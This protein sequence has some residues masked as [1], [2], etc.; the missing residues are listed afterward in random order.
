MNVNPL[1]FFI[2]S[3]LGNLTGACSLLLVSHVDP[4]IINGITAKDLVVINI[5]SS[6]IGAAAN[7]IGYHFADRK[8]GEEGTRFKKNL[9][10]STIAA[11]GF[12]AAGTG[13]IAYFQPERPAPQPTAQAQLVKLSALALRR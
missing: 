10:A 8:W 13:L 7:E 6:F 9:F 4:N 2:N 1:R 5:G 3:T 12:L 11:A